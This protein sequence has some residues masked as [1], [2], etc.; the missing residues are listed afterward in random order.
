MD[1]LGSVG[2]LQV[3]EAVTETSGSNLELTERF[4]WSLAQVSDPDTQVVQSELSTV[5]NSAHCDYI[6]CVGAVAELLAMAQ[7]RIANH[8][9]RDTLFL[10]LGTLAHRTAESKVAL[11]DLSVHECS[12]SD[13]MANSPS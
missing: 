13:D 3:V 11:N 1:I 7:E 12:S 2:S 4:L 5:T 9:M 6:H 10:T 8:K